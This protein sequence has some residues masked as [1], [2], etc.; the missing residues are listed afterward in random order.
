MDMNQLVWDGILVQPD[1]DRI[2]EIAG[3]AGDIAAH[4]GVDDE[5]IDEI[6]RLIKQLPPRWQNVAAQDVAWMYATRLEHR[7]HIAAP[8]EPSWWCHLCPP[9][10]NAQEIGRQ[11]CRP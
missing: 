9:T 1:I 6:S 3:R 2:E 11:R 10:L 8:D 7:G 4:G 5:L